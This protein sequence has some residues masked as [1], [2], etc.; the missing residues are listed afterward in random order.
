MTAVPWT[1]AVDRVNARAAAVDWRRVGVV[2]LIALPFLLFASLR[3]TARAA[4]WLGARV[5]AACM[6]GWDAAGPRRD[7]AG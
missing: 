5:W 7:G 6:V 4:G 1:V 2:V 3:Y